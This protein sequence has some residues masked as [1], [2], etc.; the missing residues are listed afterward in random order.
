MS[1]EKQA[2][3]IF[4]ASREFWWP[5][6]VRLPGDGGIVEQTFEAR[7]RLLTDDELYPEIPDGEDLRTRIERDRE[8]LRANVKGLRGIAHSDL[9]QGD[10]L[11]EEMIRY[12]PYRLAL[13]G[14]LMA[15]H[16]GEAARLGN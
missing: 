10:E 16:R 11:L 6:T 9:G 3:A 14:A 1:E 5:V 2:G 4:S 7:F 13:I 15:A 12:Q 8:F